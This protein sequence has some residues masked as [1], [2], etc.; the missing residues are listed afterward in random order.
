[1][2]RNSISLTNDSAL[3]LSTTT[4]TTANAVS[5]TTQTGPHTPR[6]TYLSNYW[7][8]TADFSSDQK[9]HMDQTIAE[10]FPKVTKLSD[11]C[12]YYNCHSY[13]WWSDT[14]CEYWINDPSDFW[15]DGSYCEIDDLAH[16]HNGD[17]ITYYNEIPHN[18]Q[19][20]GPW[21]LELTHS[22]I[23]ESAALAG[24]NHTVRSKW[25]QYGVYKHKILDCPDEYKLGS[26]YGGIWA[27]ERNPND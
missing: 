9:A 25:G 11:A 24:K 26:G 3:S 12:Y 5:S 4:S 20:Y 16:A 15:Y 17:K 7:Y 14:D 27:Y 13:A 22:A 8:S 21:P 2:E 1:M 19:Q 18:S 10:N 6:G 23:V